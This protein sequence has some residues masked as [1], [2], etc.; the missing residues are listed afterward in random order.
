[1][2]QEPARIAKVSTRAVRTA[3]GA[4]IITSYTNRVLK[5][6]RFRSVRES[7]RQL[8][9]LHLVQW[10]DRYREAAPPRVEA[11]VGRLHD[12]VGNPFAPAVAE[13][14]DARVIPA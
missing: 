9:Q 10:T 1:M 13:E 14:P 2:K 3:R 11:D 4:G 5:C 6:S 7:G 12:L 8:P